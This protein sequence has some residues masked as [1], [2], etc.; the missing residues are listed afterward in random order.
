RWLAFAVPFFGL[1]C[2]AEEQS[3]PRSVPQ[4]APVAVQPQV[5]NPVQPLANSGSALGSA[6]TMWGVIPPGMLPVAAG[7]QPFPGFQWPQGIP[8]NFPNNIPWQSIPLPP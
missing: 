1:A 5:A 7:P 2:M 3:P 6:W 8:Q 4:P